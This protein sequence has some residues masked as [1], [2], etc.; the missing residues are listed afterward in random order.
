MTTSTRDSTALSAEQK[1]RREER[2]WIQA[3]LD[4]VD[5]TPQE[6]FR[7]GVRSVAGAVKSDGLDPVK[8]DLYLRVLAT[9]YVT[10][11]MSERLNAYWERHFEPGRTAS[12]LRGA[13]RRGSKARSTR[14]K[15]AHA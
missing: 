13:R 11:L 3:W 1:A 14:N 8:A 5:S 4:A 15:A 7:E 9:E 12:R 6:I 2:E 10:A